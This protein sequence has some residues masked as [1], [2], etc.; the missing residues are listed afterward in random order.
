MFLEE[1]ADGPGLLAA[2]TT[3]PDL[4]PPSYVLHSSRGR[5]HVLWRTRGI[6]RDDVEA[7][8]KRLARELGT[9]AAATSCAQ[10]TRLPGFVNH[11]HQCPWSIFAEYL[12]PKIVLE[13]TDF[14]VPTWAASRELRV[15]AHARGA[16]SACSDRVSRARLFLDSVRPAVAGQHGDLRTFRICCRV[17][18][19]FDL[20]D[21]EALSVLNEWNARCEPPWSERELLEKVRNARRYGREPYGG[22]LEP[23]TSG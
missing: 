22:L 18:R 9:D 5:L 17:V 14:P 10:T 15:G 3:R 1:D 20:A 4:P 19:G 12:R 7:L 16:L 21:D 23:I 13:R 2:L 11:K 8:Q 6:S